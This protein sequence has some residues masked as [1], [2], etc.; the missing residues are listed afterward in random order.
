M[1]CKIKSEVLEGQVKLQ[2]HREKIRKK[3]KTSL[4]FNNISSKSSL[5]SLRVC[6]VSDQQRKVQ[7]NSKVQSQVLEAEASQVSLK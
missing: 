5:K 2:V 1:K 3:T 6:Q 7:I 4:T